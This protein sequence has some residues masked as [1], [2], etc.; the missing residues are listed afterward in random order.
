MSYYICNKICLELIYLVYD[1]R[2]FSALDQHAVALF[3]L[4]PSTAFSFIDR[5]EIIRF[6][7]FYLL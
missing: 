3:K 5:N 6:S 2:V 7:T 4:Y 1:R